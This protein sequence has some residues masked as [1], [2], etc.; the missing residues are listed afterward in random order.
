MFGLFGN[1]KGRVDHWFRGIP[2]G[3]DLNKVA[4]TFFAVKGSK[5][6]DALRRAYI[7][8]MVYNNR[9]SVVKVADNK[10]KIH[11]RFLVADVEGKHMF[12]DYAYY[13]QKLLYKAAGPDHVLDPNELKDF[14]HKDTL[15]LRDMAR[16]MRS[17][18][19]KNT[20]MSLYGLTSKQTGEVFGLKKF[21]EDFTLAG[22]H[23]IEEVKLWKDYLVYAT[24]F[25]IADQVA[26]DMKKAMPDF[27][28]LG[29]L[30]DMLYD[31]DVFA[32]TAALSTLA[33]SAFSYAA[34]Y[35]T[36]QELAAERAAAREGGGSGGGGGS[37]Y[38]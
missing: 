29:K 8:R 34:S 2:L 26:E 13:L 38:R 14:V 24:V 18:L 31:P 23:T 15:A 16:K 12:H 3:D 32:S 4:G 36:P 9:L 6:L 27:S 25:G 5:D 10:G 30:K 28:Q 7:L 1:L 22:E 21:L 17:E 33:N 20:N 11:K 37:G 19:E 35:K